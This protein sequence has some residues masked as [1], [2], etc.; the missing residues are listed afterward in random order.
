MIANSSENTKCLLLIITIKTWRKLYI[1]KIWSDDIF[2]QEY[3]LKFEK[4]IFSV[5]ILQI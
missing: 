1:K 3:F 5:N 4:V 2:G